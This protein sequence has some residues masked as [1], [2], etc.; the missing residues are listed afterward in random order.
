MDSD[1]DG[2]AIFSVGARR[3]LSQGGP[4]GIGDGNAALVIDKANATTLIQTPFGHAN[5]AH[6]AHG[7]AA[8]KRDHRRIPTIS[9][10]Q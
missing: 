9:G 7:L 1:D 10:S 6:G 3:I 4:E 5:L 8:S 2:P